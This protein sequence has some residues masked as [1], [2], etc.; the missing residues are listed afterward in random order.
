[1]DFVELCRKLISIDTTPTHG[2]RAAAEFLAGLAHHYGLAVEVQE[3]NDRG[4]AQAN[5]IVRLAR[6]F[7]SATEFMFQT[8]MDTPDPGPF[9]LWIKTGQ[10]PFEAH[11][12]DGA[13]YGLGSADCKL[14]ALCKLQALSEFGKSAPSQMTLPPVLAFTFGE[15]SGMTGAL[16]LIRKNKVRAKQALIGEPSNLQ[17]LT[18]GSGFAHV[19]IYLPFEPDELAYREEHNLRE[20]ASTISKTFAG[21]PAHAASPHEGESAIVKLFHYLGHL[22]ES[23]AVMEIEGGVN[24]NTVPAQAFLEIDPCSGF[25]LPMANKLNQIFRSMRKL[26]SE[27]LF[28]RDLDFSPPH[29]TLNMGLIRTVDSGVNMWG[30]VRIPPGITN[31]TYEKWMHQFKSEG[32]RIGAQFRVSDYKR[33]YRTDVQSPFCRQVK[34][35]AQDLGLSSETGTHSSTNEASLF[36][37]T[38]V[39]CVSFGPGRREGNIHTPNEHVTIKDLEQATRFYLEVMAR[40]CV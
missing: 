7:S 27:F 32:L 1:M 28:H 36:H 25:R 39:E 5:V 37:R 6:P 35:L 40:M 26:E 4:L 15:E 23:I 30:T 17:I 31:D 13:I 38:G 21:R 10:N 8:R 16:K 34:S 11:I 20:N 22:P 9:A 12:L 33:P 19:E 24:A 2:A 18:A 29:P 14:D 3:E